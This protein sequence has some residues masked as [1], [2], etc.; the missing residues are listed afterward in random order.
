M[1]QMK[2]QYTIFIKCDE[3]IVLGIGTK[4]TCNVQFLI[5]LKDVLSVLL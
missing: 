4:E 3:Y 1:I 2:K 5:E